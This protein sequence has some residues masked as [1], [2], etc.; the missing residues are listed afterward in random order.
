MKK[1]TQNF[2]RLFLTLGLIFGVSANSRSAES[3]PMSSGNYSEGF[4][5]IQNWTTNFA[6]GTG[7]QYYQKAAT[8]TNSTVSTSTVF[9]ANTTGGVQKGPEN[10]ILLATG[11]NSSA[12]DL[13]LNFAGTTPGTITFDYSKVVNTV[14]TRTS[15]LKLQ[16]SIDNGGSFTDFTGYDIPRVTN[17]AATESGSVTITI[18]DA[19]KEKSVIIRFYA[20]NNGQT[21]GSGNRP[22]FAIDN[23]AVTA[24]KAS[25]SDP[26]VTATDP[27]FDEIE[28]NTTETQNIEIGAENLTGNLTVVYAGADEFSIGNVTSIAQSEFA[29]GKTYTL[30]V[31]FSPT[32]AGS[33]NGTITISGG[34]LAE[35]KVITLQATSRDAALPELGKPVIAAAEDIK[36]KS[37]I[38]NW[39]AAAEAES[40]EI[41]VYIGGKAT[42]LSDLI[43]SEYVEGSSNNKAL[44]I[45]NGTGASV[46]LSTYSLKKETNGAGGYKGEVVLSGT[47]ENGETFVIVNTSGSAD[48][49]AKAD[50]LENSITGFNGNDAVGLFHNGTLIDAVGVV[51]Q[52]ADW[53]KDI[54]L[55]RKNTLTEPKAVYDVNDWDQL[56]IDSFDDLGIFA[57]EVKA[58]PVAGY[59]KNV[60]NV[61]T[62][63]VEGLTQLTTYNYTIT[64]IRGDEKVVSD[65]ATVLTKQT[66]GLEESTTST[67]VYSAQGQLIV[68]TTAGTTI[69]VYNALGQQISNIVAEEGENT[70]AIS[71]SQIV[72]VKVGNKVVKIAL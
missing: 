64:A 52:V 44:E 68:N 23:V 18:P 49:K 66:I 43:I 38:A 28:A 61:V 50:L 12:F 2:A 46:D 40:Y 32:A 26:S 11:T 5:D 53:G 39:S 60:G 59:P 10:I 57:L 55:T 69:E 25:T 71:G 62:Y 48:L 13:L 8:A 37:F 56:A 35:S 58:T 21:G 63:K 41:N 70:I 67:V 19:L 9:A 29:D 22:K 20:W 1:F 34:G 42:T 45:Y 16:Y 7:A 72:I 6:S 14:S 24:T 27:T 3:Y 33:F 17:S 51:G 30:P 47:L 15:D 54:T 4:A 31:V 65:E 36:D